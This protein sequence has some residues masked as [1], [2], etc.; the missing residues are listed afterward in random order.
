MCS[1]VT[2]R[3]V[4]SVR[5][6]SNQIIE[7]AFEYNSLEFCLFAT[8][9]TIAQNFTNISFFVITDMLS[10]PL[11]CHMLP[12]SPYFTIYKVGLAYMYCIYCYTVGVKKK[13]RILFRSTAVKRYFFN[14]SFYRCVPYRFD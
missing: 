14:R 11:Y 9:V 8:G 6:A 7:A 12:I 3:V 13:F 1:I 5:K 10:F 4:V 2:Y